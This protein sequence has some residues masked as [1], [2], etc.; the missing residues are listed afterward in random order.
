LIASSTPFLTGRPVTLFKGSS[1]FADGAVGLALFD[2]GSQQTTIEVENMQAVSPP[3]QVTQYVLGSLVGSWDAADICGRAQTNLVEALDQG[4]P[5]ESLLLAMSSQRSIDKEH[6]IYLGVI[7]TSLS[8]TPSSGDKK[9]YKYSR[10]YKITAGGPSQGTLL[11]D[12]TEG[13]QVG[14]KVQVSLIHSFLA[15][16]S[17]VWLNTVHPVYH[18]QLTSKVLD[19]IVI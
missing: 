12:A 6:D 7:D 1:I 9:V 16:E 13:P 10:V 4:N 2:Q 11:L 15:T 18:R 8:P 17:L 19:T 5:V 3:M 14:A